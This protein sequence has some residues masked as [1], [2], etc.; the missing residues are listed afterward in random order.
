[1]AKAK[2]TSEVPIGLKLKQLYE[3]QT[4]DSEIDQ[5]HVVKG[6]LPIIVSDLEDEISGL[7]TR[8]NK[9]ETSKK[10]LD[11]E[12]SNHK[13][14]IKAA[15]D[16]IKKYEKQ[17]DG[18]KNNREYDALNKEINLQ[19]LEIQLSEK[20]MKE[21][22]EQVK[23][24]KTTLEA[25]N[26]KIA[27]K[28]AE[29]DEKKEELSKILEKTDKEEATLVSKSEKSRKKIEERLLHA[30][31]TIRKRYRNGLAVV[32]VKRNA[33]GGCFNQTPPQVQL[34]IGLRKKIIACEHCGRV[35]VDD[36]IH[37]VEG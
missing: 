30:Y 26:E 19:R 17:L 4:I 28:K 9:L 31:D 36:Q 16:A 23:A 29:L 10:E 14:N 32:M 37:E 2:A 7:N 1:M 34:E 25:V 18:V 8:V 33:C 3:L 11:G 20:K 35:L 12:H 27:A 21:I 6:E 24:K 22:T 15:E 5:I 13:S